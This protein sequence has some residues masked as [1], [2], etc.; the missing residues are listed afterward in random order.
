MILVITIA[1][2]TKLTC[3]DTNNILFSI[4]IRYIIKIIIFIIH[5]IIDKLITVIIINK[6]GWL[7]CKPRLFT[8]DC[9]FVA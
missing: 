1:A 3:Y 9:F 8:V 4:F 6:R 7:Y 2:M 5:I